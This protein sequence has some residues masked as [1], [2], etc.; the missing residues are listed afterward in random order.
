MFLYLDCVLFFINRIKN[1]KIENVKKFINVRLY[2]VK[3]SIVIAPSKKGTKNITKNL[4]FSI[5]V[6]LNLKSFSQFYSFYNNP[7]L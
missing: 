3:P 2:G 6:K 4:L 5:V 1:N 7:C